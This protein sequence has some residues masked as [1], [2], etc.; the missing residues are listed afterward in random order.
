MDS[1]HDTKSKNITKDDCTASLFKLI[2]EDARITTYPIA[3]PGLFAWYQDAYK[4]YWTVEEFSPSEDAIHYE[5]RL[6]PGM[7]HFVKH[8]LAFFAASDGI[9][10]INIA[11]R[12]KK[13]VPMLEATYF[14]NFQIMMEDVHAHTYS[15]LLDAIIPSKAERASL[16]DAVKTMPVVAKMSQYMFQCINSE[17]PFAERLLRMACVEGIFFTGCFC[18]IYWLQA[19]GLM[20]A[21]GFTNELISRDEALHTMFALYLYSMLETKLPHDRVH[22][23]FAEAVEFAQ[24]FMEAGLPEAIG[25]MNSNLMMEYVKSCADNMV[26]MIGSPIMY[27]AKH[28]FHFM[29][30]INMAN[31]TNFFERRV[32]EY[33]KPVAPANSGFHVSF[34]F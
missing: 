31:R 27:R 30:Q 12:F 4:C 33:S 28:R 23:I 34:N 15:I 2:P 3:R 10:N 26:V 20:P 21:L 9:V 5:T 11:K 24:E 22:A 32:S 8:V 17:A 19:M 13:D 29:D 6:T 18:M 25:E 1:H 16:L 14:Y 7:K